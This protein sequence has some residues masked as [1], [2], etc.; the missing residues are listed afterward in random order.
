V[1]I[2]GKLVECDGKTPLSYDKLLLAP[3][4]T[5]R[6]LDV[7]GAELQNVFTLRTLDDSDRI[8]KALKDA[9]QAVVIGAS[10]IA[11][12]SAAALR[13]RG[14]DVTVVAPEVV[15][16]EHSLGGQIGSMLQDVHEQQG[17]A[18][19]LGTQVAALEGDGAVGAVSLEDGTI[20]EGDIVIVGIGVQPA[21]DFLAG[22]TKAPD[23][24][25]TVDEYLRVDEDV[26]AAGD[27]A[28]FPCRYSGESVRIEHWRL[29]Q[30]QG[31]VAAENMAGG[32]VQF[33]RVPFFW[34]NQYKV[35][36]RYVGYAS[37][38]DELIIQG[39]LADRV[40]V[41]FY[42]R[43]DRVLAVAGCKKDKQVAAAAEL[44]QLDQMPG[45]RELRE[46]SVDL[47]SRLA[48]VAGRAG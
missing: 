32:Q 23:G 17:V 12:E 10:F 37:D 44:M 34:T 47:V 4:A 25:V 15:P 48:T 30:Q 46:E 40:F 29:A 22:I 18:F 6:K 31:R 7:S 35:G 41:G 27:I 9:S 14:L 28:W 43:D 3:G 39:S 21:T 11:M 2:K 20:V 33:D 13:Q 38:W 8:R 36:L 1:D 16:F 19:R 45:A 5:P 26:Y 42:V 24:G